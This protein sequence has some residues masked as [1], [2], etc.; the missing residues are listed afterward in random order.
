MTGRAA[1]RY[2]DDG[3]LVP[4]ARMAEV[5]RAAIA[6]G[7]PGPRLMEAAGRAVTRAVVAAFAP[8]PVLVLCGPGNN[9]GDGYVCARQ[10]AAAGWQVRVAALD[11]V[12]ALHGD[13]AWARST[14]S[15]PVEAVDPELAGTPALV[16]DALFG[17][18]LSRDLDGAARR[19]VCRLGELGKQVVAVDVP[20][21]IDGTTG[22]VRGAAP[23]AAL[24]VTFAR[25]KPGHVLLPGRL[26]CGRTLLA[27]IGIPDSVVAAHDDGLRVN[28]PARWASLLPERVPD[29]HKYRYGHAVVVGGGPASTGA[30]RLAARAAA[31]V[32]AG[33]VTVAAV[34]AAIPA[35]AAHL[36]TVMTRPVADEAAWSGLL[37]DRRL[38]AF[39]IGPA[40]GI[41][42][43]T[44]T[45]VRSLLANGRPLVLDA[46]ALS[47]F[48]D[49]PS[50]LLGQLHPSC[51]LTPHDGEFARLFAHRGDRLSR[52]R[53]AAAQAGAVVVLKGADSVIAAP[54]GRASVQPEAPP[55]LATAG[56]GDVLAGLVLGLLAQGL[57]AFEAASAAVWLHAAAAAGSTAGLMAE[58]L[59]DRVPAVLDALR[60]IPPP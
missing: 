18:G 1:G 53:A 42:V 19:T 4:P 13:A 47:S 11:P 40:A 14:W 51:V 26:H 41:G 34:P 45:R 44:R 25:L 50:A 43:E 7:V 33:L 54:D 49:D 9:G 58:D 56:T 21:G 6:G 38:S 46:D 17:A 59:P 31:R 55:A 20:S 30:A 27:D 35:Y 57:P 29:G 32:G 10:L 37:A 22:A 39:L 36:T 2:G 60:R 52:A 28:A 8:Q 16:V 15:G 23:M 5:D 3:V 48:A 12:A 24:T